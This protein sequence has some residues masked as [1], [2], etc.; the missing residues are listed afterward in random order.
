MKKSEVYG[1]AIMSVINS[2][3][4]APEMIEVLSILFDDLRSAKFFELRE[5]EDNA[6]P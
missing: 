1:I 4:E 3:L 6:A 2:S 5:G